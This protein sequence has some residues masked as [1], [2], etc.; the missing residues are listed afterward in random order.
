MLVTGAAQRIGA[1]I[2][3]VAHSAGYRTAIHYRSSEKQAR[4]LVSVLNEKRPASAISIQG[5]L[6]DTTDCLAIV[7]DCIEQ[8][9]RL[10]ALINNASEFFPT[11][12]GHIDRQAIDKTFSANVYAPLFLTQA[13]ACELRRRQGVVINIVDIYASKVHPEHPV[14][15]ASKAALAMLTRSLA[16]E[17]APEVRVN[18]VAPGAILWPEG[19]AA[20]SDASIA[21]RLKQIPL[22]KIGSAD[23]IASAVLYLCSDDAAFITGQIL[24]L[25]GGRS[26]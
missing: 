6:S 18:G 10:D 9:G 16:V 21:E 5:D 24:S 8:F 1:A 4:H 2:A 20:L 26:L 23:Q 19:D 22:Q 15:C 12:L 14:Y 3:S 17:C 13:A 7:A 25:D 11:P